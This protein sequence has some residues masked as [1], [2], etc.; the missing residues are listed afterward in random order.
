MKATD[1]LELVRSIESSIRHM[2]ARMFQ[3]ESAMTD[4]V[5]KIASERDNRGRE[6][7]KINNDIDKLAFSIEHS[8][9]LFNS[10][11]L[12]GKPNVKAPKARKGK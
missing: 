7:F 10:E 3:I 8:R 4:A 11:L 6:I 5:C 12:K 2:E 9:R 1:M